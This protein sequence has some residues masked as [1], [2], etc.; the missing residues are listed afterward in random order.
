MKES[1]FEIIF[2]LSRKQ[3]W[4]ADK[5]TEL[6]SLLYKDCT[7]DEHRTLVIEL[8]DRFVHISPEKFATL[9]NELAES[10][11]TEPSLSDATTQILSMTADFN[12]DS[13]QYILYALKAPFERNGWRSHLSITNFG[14]SLKEYNRKGAVHKNIVL[15]DEFVGSGKTVIGRVNAIKQQYSQAGINDVLIKVKVI[16]SSSVGL[17]NIKNENIDIESLVV[18]DRGISDYYEAIAVQEKLRLMDELELKLSS[19]YKDRALPKLGYG[20]TESLYTRD[21]GNTPNSV[22]PV[23]W[24][25][26]LSDN[27]VRKTLLI[28]AMEDA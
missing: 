27:T 13:G 16:A 1:I 22:F 3:P 7:S 21:E 15:V 20:G 24:W 12:A 23:F 2:P 25:P 11:V 19:N 17:K 14:R 4:L 8:L 10:I 18:L 26:I 5:V 9:I 6:Q 28:R